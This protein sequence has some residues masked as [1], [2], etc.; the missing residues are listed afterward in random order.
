MP[1]PLARSRHVIVRLSKFWPRAF[2][3]AAMMLI[4]LIG[5]ILQGT[6]TLFGLK[7]VEQGASWSAPVNPA[8]EDAGRVDP[9][10][11]V[12]VAAGPDQREAVVA[13]TLHQRGV[14]RGGA[15][16]HL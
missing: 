15:I 13:L 12:A 3:R 7:S 9:V 8:S 6:R 2:R 5:C 16:G 10:G 14:D 11:S 4:P 1:G